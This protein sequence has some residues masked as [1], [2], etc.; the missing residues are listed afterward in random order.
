MACPN[1]SGAV[2][3][4]GAL[5]FLQNKIHCV[6][7]DTLGKVVKRGFEVE[8]IETAKSLIFEAA[9]TVTELSHVRKKTRKNTGTKQKTDADVD[10][11]IQLLVEADRV[12]AT[13][14][15]FAAVDINKFP[16]VP[17]EEVDGSVILE[18]V[19]SSLTNEAVK[20]MKEGLS[21]EIDTAI[22]ECGASLGELTSS[23]KD[24]LQRINKELSVIQQKVHEVTDTIANVRRSVL[25]KAVSY[26]EDRVVSTKGNSEDKSVM[27]EQDGHVDMESGENSVRVEYDKASYAKVVKSSIAQVDVS[28]GVAGYKAS[29]N[30]GW[31]LVDKLR[32]RKIKTFLGQKKQSGT[33]GKCLRT[34]VRKKRDYWDVYVGSLA[35]D[36]TKLE[37]EG[38]LGENGVDVMQCWLLGSKIQSSLSARVR[39]PIQ[40]REKV[41]D[42]EFWPEGVRVRSWVMKPERY[43]ASTNSNH[44]D[45]E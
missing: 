41:L 44:D 35:D 30:E 26:A 31:V 22:S 37:I 9:S 20:S 5:C 25:Q 33:E 4:S 3:V 12:N 32:Q 10:D 1:D 14:T 29:A 17:L 6:P 40:D 23:V 27:G 19:A 45:V 36:T 39:I 7:L 34:V 13:L 43:H 15:R 24:E 16:H 21:L 11:I 38:F 2:L 42:E 18:K 8:E 28:K